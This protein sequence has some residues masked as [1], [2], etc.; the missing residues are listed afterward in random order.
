LFRRYQISYV[1]TTKFSI[2]EIAS[3]IL[4]STNVERRVRS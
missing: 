2:E 3:T 4:S 1:D